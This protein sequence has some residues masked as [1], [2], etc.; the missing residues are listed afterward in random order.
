MDWLDHLPADRRAPVG[1][2]VTKVVGQ[3]PYC[4]K[5]VRRCDSRGLDADEVIGC[6]ACVTRVEGSCGICKQ[7]VSRQHK[8]DRDAGFGLVHRK[9]LDD[10]T[11][12]R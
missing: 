1:A 5:R 4:G 12:R 7:D 3:C 2:F 10:R 6:F 11:R 9:C 8:R